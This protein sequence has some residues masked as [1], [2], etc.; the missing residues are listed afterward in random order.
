MVPVS[1]PTATKDAWRRLRSDSSSP[2]RLGRDTS[3]SWRGR[4]ARLS[5]SGGGETD[6]G[7]EAMRPAFGRALLLVL[8]TDSPQILVWP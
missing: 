2:L 8:I 6:A 4:D 3:E 5:N 1:V 7:A